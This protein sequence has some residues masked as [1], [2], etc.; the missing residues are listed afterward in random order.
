LTSPIDKI[1]AASTVT[2]PASLTSKQPTGAAKNQLDQDSFLKLLVAQLK[3][4]DPSNPTDSSTFMAQTA[5]F[6]QVQ[7]LQSVADTQ[8]QMLSAQLMQN[9]SSLVGHTVAY[10][11]PN[12]REATGVVTSATFNGSNPTVQVGGTDVELSAVKKVETSTSA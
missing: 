3:Y 9:A 12:G 5:Q 6:T 11:A 1:V 7:K 2:P 10:T 8:T 4:Q